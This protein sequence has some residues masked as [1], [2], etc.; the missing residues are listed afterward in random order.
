MIE[1][2]RFIDANVLVYAFDKDEARKHPIA[3]KLIERA[4]NGEENFFISNQ[5]LAEFI[6]VIT[7]KIRTP[8]SYELA[9]NILNDFLI[10]S[11]I[12]FDYSIK[13]I[14]LAL[15]ITKKYK[16]SHWDSILAATML[17]NNIHEIYTEDEA[18]GNV[19]GI[20]VINPFK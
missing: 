2:K 4:W 14:V 7:Q 16:L 6:K 10:S 13:T 5:V 12:I 3:R 18:I 19:P 1:T 8:Y 11:W 15:Q 9:E 20:K 17:E